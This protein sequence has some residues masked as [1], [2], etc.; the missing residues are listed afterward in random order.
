MGVG[1]FVQNVV[2]VVWVFPWGAF[3][4]G[5]IILVFFAFCP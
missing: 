4:L 1:G 5:A 2:I 3:V